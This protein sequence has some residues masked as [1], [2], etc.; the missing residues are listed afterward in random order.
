[1]T[2]KYTNMPLDRCSNT[3]ADI[4][5]LENQFRHK[6]SCFVIINNGLNLFNEKKSAVFLNQEN[7]TG[8]D[9]K[10]CIFLGKNTHQAFF[11]IAFEHLNN[12]A[13]ATVNSRYQF[14]NLLQASPFISEAEASIL[15]YAKAIMHWHSSHEFC[16]QCGNKN[17]LVEAGHSR[18][19]SNTNCN[20][21][22]FPR[23]DPAVIMIVE[24][25]FE[26]GIT[27]CLMGRQAEWPQGMY[28]TLAGFVDPGESLEEAVIREVFEESGISVKDV[29]Y[30]QSQP[31][32]YPA[33]IM[34]GFIATAISPQLNINKDELDDARWFSRD[35]LDAFGEMNDD[36]LAF[37]KTGKESISRFLA[38]YWH[39]ELAN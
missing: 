33:S 12:T 18:R 11:A 19:C 37:K 32:P 24:H 36:T 17:T 30:I 7:V 25:T 5:W 34:L 39:Y 10:D 6:D 15:A 3:R 23:T 21:Q 14:L 13:Q 28:S 26:D 16:G 31:W 35:E 27:R 4:S 38:D 1:M 22:T 20:Q 9:L 29:R 2:L 8:I